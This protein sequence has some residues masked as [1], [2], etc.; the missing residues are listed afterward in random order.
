MD[1]KLTFAV[2]ALLATTLVS[3]LSG[4]YSYKSIL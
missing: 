4:S 2:D 3:N 1:K